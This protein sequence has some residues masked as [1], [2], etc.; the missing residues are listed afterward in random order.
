[1]WPM[2]QIVV[3][4]PYCGS[5]EV[6]SG[7]QDG[8]A[9]FVRVGAVGSTFHGGG[10]LFIGLLYLALGPGAL[11]FHVWRLAHNAWSLRVHGREGAD[12]ELLHRAKR[13]LPWNVIITLLPFFPSMCQQLQFFN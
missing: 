11:L 9:G 5:A 12:Y 4:G 8:R 7:S 6:R 13:C 3:G 1:M 10:G 2:C